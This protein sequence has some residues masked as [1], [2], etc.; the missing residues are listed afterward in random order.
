MGHKPFNS[1]KFVMMKIFSSLILL[2]SGIYALAQERGSFSFASPPA[3]FIQQRPDISNKNIQSDN[4]K[5]RSPFSQKFVGAVGGVSFQNVANPDS[6]LL[7]SSVN[8]QYNPQNTDGKR[9]ELQI[10]GARVNFQL[11]DWQAIPIA[12]FA[13][14]EFTSCFTYFGKLKNEQLEKIILENKGHV[15]NYHPAFSNTLVGWRLADMDMLI[16]YD[17]T[18]DL[19]KSN[20]KYL[21]GAGETKPNLEANQRGAYRFHN[22]INTVQN[23]FGYRFQSYVI[24]DFPRQ[25]DFTVNNDSLLISGYPYYYCWYYQYQEPGFDVNAVADSLSEHFLG[26]INS[27][28]SSDS[29][30]NIHE[31]LIDSLIATS[32]EYEKNFDMYKAGTFS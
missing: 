22:H 21:L 20:N 26:I 30:F 8:L 23:T 4:E 27:G 10:N 11:F 14:S 16:L 5:S 17:F 28:K 29:G 15:L 25:T 13:N 1:P 2:L 31:F 24:S 12:K 32:I 18:T 9:V 6:A 19:P 3:Q 7:I